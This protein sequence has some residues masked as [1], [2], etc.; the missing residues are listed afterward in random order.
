MSSSTSRKS[1][2][3]ARPSASTADDQSFYTT[4]SS[5][6]AS[7]YDK[8]ANAVLMDNNIC[9][10]SYSAQPSNIDAIRATLDIPRR[11]FSPSVYPD[12]KFD[13]F[14]RACHKATNEH[15]LMVEVIHPFLTS[16]LHHTASG[17]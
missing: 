4:A 7:T 13:D 5:E 2:K 16:Y 10:P 1:R 9:G 17:D 11:S 15:Y 12:V 3:R 8:D 6:H 14:K